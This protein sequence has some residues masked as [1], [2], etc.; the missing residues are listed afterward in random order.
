MILG[1]SLRI[2]YITGLRSCTDTIIHVGKDTDYYNSIFLDRDMIVD[3]GATISVFC[4][5]YISPNTRV[6]VRPGG[7]LIVDGGTLTSACAGEM[8]QGIEVV[9]DRTRHQNEANQGTVILRNGA[10]IENAHC[11]IKTGLAGNEWLTAGG[12]VQCTGATFKNNRRAVEFLSYADTLASGNIGDNKSWFKNCT[13]TLNN[14]NLFL[15]R[16][17]EFLNHVTLWDVKGVSFEGCTFE[18][19]TAGNTTD[20]K[21]GIYALGAGFKVN[22]LCNT[23][24]G[25]NCYGAADTSLFAGF[26]TAVEIGNDG[27]PYTVTIDEALFGNNATGVFIH[28]CDYA[29]ITRCTFDLSTN[30]VNTRNTLGLRLDNSTGFHVEGNSFTAAANATAPSRTGIQVRKSGYRDNSIY[31]NTLENLDYGIFVTDTNGSQRSGLCFTCNTFDDCTYGI[32]VDDDA[33]VSPDQGL[34]TKGAANVFT[35]SQASSFYN[36]GP[37]QTTYHYKAQQGHHLYQAVG[38]TLDSVKVGINP[39]P[40]TVCDNAGNITPVTN[41]AGLDGTGDTMPGISSGEAPDG[42]V[43]SH[44][45]YLQDDDSYAA[46]L[47]AIDNYYASV[48]RIMADSV[49]NLPDLLAWHTAAGALATP[50]ALTETAAAMGTPATAVSPMAAALTAGPSLTPQI[51]QPELDNYAAFRALADALRPSSNNPAV[52]W[53]AASPAQINELQRIAEAN[54]GRSSAM[55]RG[56]LCF[57]FDICHEEEE[58]SDTKSGAHSSKDPGIPQWTYWDLALTEPVYYPHS[59][60]LYEDTVLQGMTFRK[61]D[62]PMTAVNYHDVEVLLYEDS[63]GMYYWDNILQEPRVLYDYTAGPGDIY[64]VYPL[65]GDTMYQIRVSVD[66]V[67][68]EIIDSQPLHVFYV[69]TSSVSHQDPPLFWTFDING[70]HHARIIEHIGATGFLLPMETA[71]HDQ[72]FVSLCEYVNEKLFYKPTDTIDCQEPYVY[73]IPEHEQPMV[74]LYPNPAANSITIS[75]VAAITRVAAYNAQGQLMTVASMQ[76]QTSYGMDVSQWPKG[77]Y[78]LHVETETGTTVLKMVKL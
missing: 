67:R 38:V 48:R 8:W 39:C 53:P 76:G 45:P 17:L 64:T 2:N 54:T 51:S 42:T 31:R 35:G 30:P 52:N 62:F 22:T 10:T 36:I 57:F 70:A 24:D 34:K 49:E 69:T 43:V 1:N 68:I 3:S 26:S 25:C 37:W 20:R 21:H 44:T 4:T 14:D 40:S 46:L 47:T 63:T 33:I 55:A 60:A 5:M 12:I 61:S 66:S 75:G 32:Y 15:S 50:Y 59:F 56:V 29:T 16:G 41:F 13:F 27:C 18:N 78:F 73:D 71:F 7:T 58:E 6:I 11:A 19:S 23:L 74:Q 77:L 9:G 28:A 65:M 72:Y